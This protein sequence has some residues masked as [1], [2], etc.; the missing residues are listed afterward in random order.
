M[1]IEMTIGNTLKD[2]RIS[3]NVKQDDI[4][5]QMGVTVQTVSKWERDITEPKASQVHQLSKVLKLSEKEICQG[6]TLDA[7]N[8][9]FDFVRKVSILMSEVPHTEL[10]VGMQEFIDDENGFLEMLAGISDYPFDLFDARKNELNEFQQ[11]NEIMFE[12]YEQGGVKFDNK[13]FEEKFVKE[14]N[15]WKTKQ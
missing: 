2:R 7:K 14:Y 5:E 11:N 8:E 1:N 15:D 12:A 6:K 4:A 10:L 9:P 13:E 3:L